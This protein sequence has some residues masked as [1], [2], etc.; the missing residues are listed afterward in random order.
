MCV[1]LCGYSKCVTSVPRCF[2]YLLLFH[3]K[4]SASL[5]LSLCFPVSPLLFT[6]QLFLAR[7]AE[8]KDRHYSVNGE[9]FLSVGHSASCASF[10]T[11]GN[12]LESLSR[13]SLTHT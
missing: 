13:H 10:K 8:N 3:F 11:H 9:V 4:Q 12:P 1:I 2:L 6:G 7:R 5:Y